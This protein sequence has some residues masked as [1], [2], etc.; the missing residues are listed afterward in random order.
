MPDPNSDLQ[1]KICRAVK[2]LLLAEGAGSAGDTF[3]Q[4]CSDPRTFPNT[5]IECPEGEELVKYS[6]IWKFTNVRVTMRDAATVQPTETNQNAAWIAA[7]ERYNR[8]HT[9]LSRVGD[10]GEF[11]FLPAL[12]TEAGRALADSD[13]SEDGDQQQEDNADMATFTITWWHCTGL[14]APR[15]DDAGTCY[16]SELQFECHACNGNV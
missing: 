6:G 15:S 16:E 2:A 5:T 13:G 3:V 10:N 11:T 1:S 9:A 12:L 8:I 7:T 14:S 4:F